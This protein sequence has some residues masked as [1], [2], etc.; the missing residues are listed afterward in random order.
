VKLL[1]YY[2]S[3]NVKHRAHSPTALNR[4]Q[5]INL[6]LISIRNMLQLIVQLNP[7]DRTPCKETED[8]TQPV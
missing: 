3:G 7:V 1:A 4:L 5:R 8:L 2:I 6:C